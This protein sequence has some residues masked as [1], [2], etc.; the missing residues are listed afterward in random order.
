MHYALEPVQAF[1]LPYE[2][3]T[4][5]SVTIMEFPLLWVSCALF[6][7]VFVLLVMRKKDVLL[8]FICISL[9]RKE[10]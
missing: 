8:R 1:S 2:R 10:T 4:I 7:A 6:M 5:S 9:A 3:R